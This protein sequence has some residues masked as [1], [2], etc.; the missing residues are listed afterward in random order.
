MLPLSGLKVPDD[1]DLAEAFLKRVQNSQDLNRL[2][3]RMA[4][5]EYLKKAAARY[6]ETCNQKIRFKRLI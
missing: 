6:P 3:V 1:D 2:G 5:E 4:A